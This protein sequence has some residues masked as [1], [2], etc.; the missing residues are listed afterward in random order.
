MNYAVKRQAF[1]TLIRI[2]TKIEKIE[3]FI[4]TELKLLRLS[5]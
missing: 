2:Q 4:R 1:V 5:R 3:F